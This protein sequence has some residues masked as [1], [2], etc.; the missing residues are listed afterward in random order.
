M[1][2]LPPL[3]SESAAPDGEH[4]LLPRSASAGSV[5]GTL[6]VFGARESGLG[7]TVGGSSGGGLSARH[8]GQ[9]SDEANIPPTLA[10]T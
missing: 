5:G 6:T 7:G 9:R 1:P 3:V 2:L 10:N 8:G 4:R